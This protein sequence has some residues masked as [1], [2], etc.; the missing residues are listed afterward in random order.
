MPTGIA[1]QDARER[2][3]AAAERILLRDGPSGLTSRAVTDE[4]GVAKGVLHRHFADF[5]DFLRFS[6]F[7][8]P[9]DLS[10]SVYT[11]DDR[12]LYKSRR[13]LGG[14]VKEND[15]TDSALEWEEFGASTIGESGNM[16]V[17]EVQATL[18]IFCKR[19]K[20]RHLVF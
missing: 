14:M 1:L 11:R 5:D 19:Q 20:G 15:G 16:G 18:S 6:L 4:A 7:E 13:V 10:T 17:G 2:L 9:H 12:K 8:N 3:F